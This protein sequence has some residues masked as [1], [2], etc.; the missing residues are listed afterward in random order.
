[1]ATIHE[2]NDQ[3]LELQKDKQFADAEAIF[4]QVLGRDPVNRVALFGVA[5]CRDMQGDRAGAKRRYGEAIAKDPWLL[6]AA[7][8][9]ANLEE[10]DNNIEDSIRLTQETLKINPSN[11]KIWLLLAARLVIGKRFDEANSAYQKAMGYAPKDTKIL[12]QYYFFLLS[13]G[14]AAETQ[15]LIDA[16]V[17]ANPNDLGVLQAAGEIAQQTGR[18]Q[19]A[20]NYYTRILKIDPFNPDACMNLAMILDVSGRREEA[21]QIRSRGLSRSRVFK[22]K[23]PSSASSHKILVLEAP[24]GGMSSGNL[25]PDEHYEKTRLILEPGLNKLPEELGQFDLVV[26]GLCEIDH[27]LQAEAAAMVALLGRVCLNA[28]VLG[29]RRGRCD[30]EYL[31]GGIDRLSTIP[32][33]RVPSALLMSEAVPA[34]V[35]PVAMPYIA[36]WVLIPDVQT[37]AAVAQQLGCDWFDYTP[38]PAIQGSDGLTR[39]IRATAIGGEIRPYRLLASHLPCID[40]SGQ[41]VAQEVWLAAEEKGLIETADKFLPPI[42]GQALYRFV[43]RLNLD[44]AVID[45]V[46]DSHRLLVLDVMPYPVFLSKLQAPHLEHQ[47]SADRALFQSIN[48]LVESKLAK[49]V[50]S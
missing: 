20:V 38:I 4:Q 1:M 33:R 18:L 3:A 5:Y 13:I 42:M 10:M 7:I 32:V 19:D 8:N 2:L 37:L 16:A 15:P 24:E 31:V 29:E 30:L 40:P 46:Y 50:T 45:F 41:L 44:L 22:Q 12:L 34:W 35:R 25:F 28:P 27:P 36:N 14:R 17:S 43:Q 49:A 48:R 26:N 6:E 11:P 23:F 9:L 47:A 21:K 39:V